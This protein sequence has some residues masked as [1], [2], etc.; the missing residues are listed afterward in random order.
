MLG[1]DK[2][3]FVPDARARA[4]PRIKDD[5]KGGVA[6]DD[7]GELDINLLHPFLDDNLDFLLLNS[8]PAILVSIIPGQVD[9]LC[10]TI[11]RIDVI[12]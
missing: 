6:I 10:N 7:K 9:D 1:V 4:R 3:D 5:A 11:C 8:V 12:L 2:A